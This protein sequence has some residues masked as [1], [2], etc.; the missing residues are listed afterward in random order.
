MKDELEKAKRMVFFQRPDTRLR[1]TAELVGRTVEL[2][3]MNRHAGR[4]GGSDGSVGS[5]GSDAAAGRPC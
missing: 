5:V 1:A 4:R 2:F 3:D